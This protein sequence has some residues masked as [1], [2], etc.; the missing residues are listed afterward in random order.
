[1][2]R[3]IPTSRIDFAS[4]FYELE[5]TWL[6]DVMACYHLTKELRLKERPV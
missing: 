3:M 5:W 2:E 6:G 4:V 1:M